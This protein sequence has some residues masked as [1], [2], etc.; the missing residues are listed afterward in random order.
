[1]NQSEDMLWNPIPPTA[2][3]TFALFENQIFPGMWFSQNDKG[4]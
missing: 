3:S 1:M 4:P 2:L